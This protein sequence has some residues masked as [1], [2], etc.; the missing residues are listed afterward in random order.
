MR[1]SD[2]GL[3][4]S[5]RSPIT[6]A[7][8][9]PVLAADGK[10]KEWL[11]LFPI[12]DVVTNDNRRWTIPDRAWADKLVAASRKRAGG[13]ELPFDYDHQTVFS[14]VPG[15][16]G[17][18]KASGWFKGLEV[19]EDGIYVRPEWTR[20]AAT[21]IDDKEY[22]Y[23][24]PTFVDDD[25]GRVAC[26][27][28]A[29]LTNTPALDLGAVASSDLDLNRDTNMLK[30]IAAALGLPETASQA[31]VLAA[32]AAGKTAQTAA[33]GVL[34][35]IRT[36]AGLAADADAP[37]VCA[38]ITAMKTTT[39]VDGDLQQAVITLTA[40]VNS[41]KSAGAR[42]AAEDMV[43]AAIKA[44]QIVPATRDVFI[45]L[46]TDKPAEFT[47]LIGVQPV[48]LAPG[49]GDRAKVDLEAITLSDVERAACA[50]TGVSETDFLAQK[51]KDAA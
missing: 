20:S 23:I 6:A 2:R 38:A 47:K 29:A 26:I 44:G 25:Q 14:A 49:G 30:E 15:V 33:T 45:T 11:L 32:I 5:Q 36:A 50:A 48:V 13:R 41:L 37:A 42:K 17:T 24:S 1:T 18:A 27:W 19:R 31:D 8:Y 28:G 51:K 21:A 4:L 12:G 35:E 43:D 34:A 9:T 10:P 39:P 22:R 40:E 16:G 3:R 7:V 46:A